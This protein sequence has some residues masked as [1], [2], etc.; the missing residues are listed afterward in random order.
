[1]KYIS[2][3]FWTL[4][5]V[6]GDYGTGAISKEHA[7]KQPPAAE[8]PTFKEGDSFTYKNWTG[9]WTLT[10]LGENDGLLLF[11]HANPKRSW[12]VYLTRDLALVRT[13]GRG[14][15]IDNTPRDGSL[16]FPLYVG[17]TWVHQYV[18]EM[19]GSRQSY[20]RE[21]R[22]KVV[23]W[24]QVRVPAGTF[25]AYRVEIENAWVGHGVADETYWYAPEVGFT[26]KYA[27][28]AWRWEYELVKFNK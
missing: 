25:W 12:E 23:A 2:V 22:A 4:V 11:K 7:A 28:Q 18:H 26:I 17:K 19:K 16:E 21:A 6:L 9:Q 20:Q 27:S 15:D 24:E 5:L 13:K 10:Y 14:D 8:R 3:L 1:M